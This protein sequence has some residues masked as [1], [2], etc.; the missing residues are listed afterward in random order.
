MF[1]QT[2]VGRVVYRAEGGMRVLQNAHYRWLQFSDSAIQTLVKRKTPHKPV[3]R[4]LE[5]FSLAARL[6]QGSTCVLG[7]GGGALLH[8]LAHEHP[9]MPLLAI[10]RCPEVLELAH[11]YFAL[12]TLTTTR[13]LQADAFDFLKKTKES[14]DHLLVD[15]AN[16][17]GLP[18]ACYQET[19]FN[20]CKRVLNENGILALNLSTPEYHQA[21]LEPLRAVFGE[22][23]NIPIRGC[24]N[25]IIFASRERRILSLLN[26]AQFSA[27][28][29][30]IE[31]VESV[32][33]VG[34]C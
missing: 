5:A 12:N 19:F 11:T 8:F 34:W 29:K 26:H 22:V 10:E 32:G 1:W 18:A 15:L 23:L 21:L 16:A 30:R 31:W 20:D 33:W 6:F 27:Y 14:F 28:F 4:Y 7:A 24:A 2:L 17:D 3:M 13:V 9:D 25:I